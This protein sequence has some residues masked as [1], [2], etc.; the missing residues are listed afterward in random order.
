MRRLGGLGPGG[1]RE[2]VLRAFPKAFFRRHAEGLLGREAA[3]LGL[4]AG[5]GIPVAEFQAVDANGE[6][7]RPTWMSPT[8]RPRWRCCTAPRWVYGSP[9]GT[10]RRAA[11]SPTARQTSC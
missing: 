4:L 8:A 2:L 6:H 10:A 7:P 9:S 1:R 5:T 11:G 3:V